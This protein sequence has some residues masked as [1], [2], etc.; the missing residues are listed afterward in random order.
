MWGLTVPLSRR[1]D[2]PALPISTAKT[3]KSS[4]AQHFEAISLVIRTEIHGRF[5]PP[6]LQS[7][8][9]AGPVSVERNLA[10]DHLPPQRV[11][12]F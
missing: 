1:L 10:L 2:G 12:A 4:H 7:D 6:S 11:Y 9:L 8:T 5:T 3:R